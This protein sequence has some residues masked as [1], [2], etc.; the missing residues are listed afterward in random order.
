MKFNWGTNIAIVYIAFLIFSIGTAVYFMNMDV[1]LVSSDYYEQELQYQDRINSINRA[2]K[3]EEKVTIENGEKEVKVIFPKI[4]DHKLITGEIHLY[5]PSDERLDLKYD[6]NLDS[7][8]IVSIGK[9]KLLPGYWKMKVDWRVKSVKYFNE[10]K[11]F[12]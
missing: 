7:T 4:F 6:I 5:R 2:N 12:L 8:N 10:F 1:N 11:V 3:L 9:E